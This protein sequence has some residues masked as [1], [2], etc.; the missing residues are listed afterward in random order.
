L[1]PML[2][3]ALLMARG[4]DAALT[5]KRWQSALMMAL[6]GVA[7]AIAA[8]VPTLLGAKAGD[9]GASATVTTA[10]THAGLVALAAVLFVGGLAEKAPRAPLLAGLVILDL[11]VVSPWAL[12]TW[13]PPPPSPLLAGEPE[14]VLFS[15][16][17]ITSASQKLPRRPSER[18]RFEDAMSRPN[19]GIQRN[20]R[21]V[22]GVTSMEF[23][24][25]RLLREAVGLEDA[26]VRFQARHAVA[27]ARHKFRLFSPV[28]PLGLGIELFRHEG[29]LPPVTCTGTWQVVPTPA[30][31]ARL[32]KSGH[33]VDG[34]SA[35]ASPGLPE[36]PC[37]L[38][39]L[40]PGEMHLSLSAQTHDTLAI[41][42]ES[43]Y[44]GW[45]AST[46]GA[47]VVP[48]DVAMLGVHLPAGTSEVT[49][50]FW[51]NWLWPSL[52]AS[53]LGLLLAIAAALFKRKSVLQGT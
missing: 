29:P 35:P 40:G 34:A 24:R 47:A 41:V 42:S 5:L 12:A 16:L 25:T 17:D 52:L 36:V 33:V 44:P 28:Q 45:Q 39:R 1:L 4:V 9:A 21:S 31:A 19:L 6:P 22:S 18:R 50:R 32:V 38:Q 23:T 10:A 20:I 26:A 7:A 48:A 27:D 3:L 13:T 8:A 15:T 14:R 30:E 49:L 53:A 46:P 2:T 43:Y 37:T 51:P 11:V